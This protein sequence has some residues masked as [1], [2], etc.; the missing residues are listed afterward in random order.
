[1]QP[2]MCFDWISQLAVL[3]LGRNAVNDQLLVSAVLVEFGG[4]FFQA[5]A[6]PEGLTNIPGLVNNLLLFDALCEQDIEGTDRHAATNE[7]TV[8]G[9]RTALHESSHNT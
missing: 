3:L 2:I 9:E 5:C 6:T 7:K 1:M 4:D 8:P